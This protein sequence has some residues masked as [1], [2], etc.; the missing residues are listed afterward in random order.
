MSTRSE[1]PEPKAPRARAEDE[2]SSLAEPRARFEGN[3]PA[4]ALYA[5]FG[6]RPLGAV[7]L[8]DPRDPAIRGEG[9]LMVMAAPLDPETLRKKIAPL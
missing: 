5:G 7:D 1:R 3:L 4:V 6:F 2:G 9:R 8:P